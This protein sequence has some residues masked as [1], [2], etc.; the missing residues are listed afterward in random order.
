LVHQKLDDSDD[1]TEYAR[2]E[3]YKIPDQRTV[4]SA[5]GACDL[6]RSM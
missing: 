1:L 3:H 6:L 5:S 4:Q 2:N